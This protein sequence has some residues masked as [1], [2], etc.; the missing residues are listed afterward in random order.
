MSDSP[1]LSFSPI[2]NYPRQAQIGKTYL[3]TIDLQPDEGYEWKFKEEEYP[4]Y[5]TVDSDIFT[6][7]VVGE[8]I[9][10]MHRFGGSYGAARFL[11]TALPK[12]GR[13]EIKVCLINAWG[14]TVKVLEVTQIDILESF[15]IPGFSPDIKVPVYKSIKDTNPGICQ[16]TQIVQTDRIYEAKLIIIGEGGAGKTTLS[17]KIQSSD[18]QLHKEN[19]TQGI[20]VTQ[21]QFS[22]KDGEESRVNIWDFGGQEIY[23]ATHQ[24]FFSKRTLYILVVD[25]RREDTDFY[26]WLNLVKLLSGNSPLL[27]I[28]NEKQD[29]KREI[30]ERLLRSEFTNL[31]EILSTNLETNRGLPEI[32]KQI[33]HHMSSLPHVGTELPKTWIKVRQVLEQ[34]SRNYISLDEYL[35]LCEHNGFD[36]HEEK[37]QLS[38]YLHDLGVCLHFQE[39]QLLIKMVILKPTWGTDAVYKVLDNPRVISNQGRF[40]RDDL[41]QIWYEDKYAT[42]Q[43]EL[44]RLMMNFKL[45][46]EIPNVPKTYIAPHLLTPNQPDYAWDESENLLLRYEY[47]FMPKGILTWFIVEMYAWIESQSC[48]WKSGVV[49]SKDGARAEVTELYRY[50]KGEIRIRVSGKRQRDL[51]TIIRHELGKIHDSYNYSDDLQNQVQR[52]KYK[53]L[54]PCNCSTCRD[55]DDPYFYSLDII[56]KFRDAQKDIQ[57]QNSFDMVNVYGLIGDIAP[58]SYS[59]SN[60]IKPRSEGINNAIEGELKIRNEKLAKLHSDLS[61]ETDTAIQFQLE[62]KVKQAIKKIQDLEYQLNELSRSDELEDEDSDIE[63]QEIEFEVVTIKFREAPALVPF[64]FE[65]AT[66]IVSETNTV[67]RTLRQSGI[68]IERSR[69]R[70]YQFV[71]SLSDRV[72][73]EMVQIPA[74]E[75]VMGAPKEEFESKDFE[76]PQHLVNVPEFYLGRYPVTQEQ[77]RFGA[78]LPKIDCELKLDPSH[79]KGNNLPVESVSWYDTIEFCG[80]LSHH[81]KRE[82]RLPSE[83]EWEYACRAGTT[84]PFHFGETITT[85][86]ANYSGE[87]NYGRGSKGIYR[88]ET[89]PVDMFPPNAFGLYDLHGNI[90]EWCQDHDCGDYTRAPINGSAWLINTAVRNAQ[91]IARGGN[92]YFS[93]HQCRSASRYGLYSDYHDF[94]TGFRIACSA[95]S[96]R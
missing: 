57:C 11:M 62:N 39:D 78:S 59:P 81:T 94:T 79:H 20:D 7:K 46:Y 31:Q 15:E 10:L 24:F 85:D 49:L 22:L 83:A 6:S 65:V 93:A 4:I 84:T 86:L 13:G 56:Y 14:V 89:T 53:T 72:I 91:R 82:Y 75:F 30:N 32:L 50:H 47:E 8:P 77:W 34:E 42:M 40:T 21:W 67:Q 54:I 9:I 36:R 23:H 96:T 44:L 76:R 66:L 28:K 63:W 51:F 95:D 2:I 80:R 29:K 43:P 27:I 1:I 16:A 58:K 12:V 41:K 26:Y 74:G 68:K 3:M 33:K 37:L 70:A 5:C 45:C 87:N 73:L 18:Y 52:L 64:D 69:G 55:S 71:E 17:K 90:W 35:N 60:A 61:I 48:V 92:F 25:A 38:E 19:S 88:G